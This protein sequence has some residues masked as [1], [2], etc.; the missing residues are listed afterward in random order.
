M[1]LWQALFGSNP[2]SEPHRPV[3]GEDRPEY[4]RLA[5]RRDLAEDARH[6]YWSARGKGERGEEASAGRPPRIWGLRRAAR[7]LSQEIERGGRRPPIELPS[8]KRWKLQRRLEKL[9]GSFA[10]AE[11]PGEVREIA[12]SARRRHPLGQWRKVQRT[13]R[14][15]RES[16]FEKLERG[17]VSPEEL[18]RAEILYNSRIG[19]F[20]R[21][22]NRRLLRPTARIRL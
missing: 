8:R 16:Y 7:R 18:R 21:Q 17:G 4:G 6:Q 22:L 9:S 11:T 15:G 20:E 13:L 14:R 19:R 12:R 2:G 10:E 3:E 1:G 5:E